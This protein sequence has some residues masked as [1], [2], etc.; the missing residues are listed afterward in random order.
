MQSHA[1]PL[2]E[3]SGHYLKLIEGISTVRKHFELLQWLQNDIQHCLP[4]DIL[5]VGWGNFQEGLVQHDILSKLPGVRSYAVGT[6]SLPF[7]LGK[8]YDCWI[9]AGKKPIHLDFC[10]F[11]YLLGNNSLPGSFGSAL[12]RMRSVLIHGMCD[13]RGQYECLYVML[14]SRVIPEEPSSTSLRILLPFIDSA[15]RQ[16][17]HL[18]QQ[19]RQPSKP[20][21]TAQEDAFGLSEREIQ[22][23]DWV[24]MGKTNSE[25]GSILNISG[26]TVKN[27]MQ[28]IF[29]KLN[30]FNR[31]QAVSKINGV[32]FNG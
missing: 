22:I 19:Q 23:M 16:I 8:F 13:E 6:D 3:G 7:L 4:H 29:Q 2:S 21:R 5:L 18:P 25:I 10:N 12:R 26:F 31:A 11:E 27:H 15:L 20:S 24:A 14:S 1:V 30:V 28:R 9:T 17:A 32:T